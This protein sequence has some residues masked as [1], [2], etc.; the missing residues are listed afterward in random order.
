MDKHVR[1][2]RFMLS[3]TAVDRRF[4]EAE[5][6]RLALTEQWARCA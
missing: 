2:I 1:D 5:I 6:A 4:L 3:G